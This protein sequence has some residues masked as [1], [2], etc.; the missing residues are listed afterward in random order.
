MRKSSKTL[1]DFEQLLLFAVLRLGEQAYGVKI[2]QE[3]EARTGRVISA[4]AIYT[5]LDRLVGRGLVTSRMG[6]PTAQRGGRR[7]KYYRLD[8]SGARMLQISYRNLQRMAD[9]QLP[10][11]REVAEGG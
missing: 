2:R 11:L 4:G 6:E 8:P 9:G 3:I 10:V 7:K 1:G 5:S